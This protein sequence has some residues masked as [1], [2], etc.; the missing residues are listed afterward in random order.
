MPPPATFNDVGT[1]QEERVDA[2][3][4]ACSPPSEFKD[5]EL[6]SMSTSMST[7]HRVPRSGNYVSVGRA[8]AGFVLEEGGGVE[9]EWWRVDPFPLQLSAVSCRKFGDRFALI[10]AQWYRLHA[11]L[12]R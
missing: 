12:R 4:A 2:R 10:L 6:V 9:V 8:T 5:R 7:E 1:L 3:G 11:A